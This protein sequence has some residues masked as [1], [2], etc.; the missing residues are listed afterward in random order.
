MVVRSPFYGMRFI[1]F[2]RWRIIN[3]DPMFQHRYIHPLRRVPTHCN[4]V[5]T[6]ESA[7]AADLG[8]VGE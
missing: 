1:D 3:T 8:T 6:I 5:S 7:V 4:T 2:G